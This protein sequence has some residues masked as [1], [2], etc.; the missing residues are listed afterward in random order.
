[1]FIYSCYGLCFCAP[2]PQKS[3]V[4]A[5]TLNIVV[6]GG[7][8]FGEIIRFRWV[9]LCDGICRLVGRGR[10]QSPPSPL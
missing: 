3:Y 9:R 6:L 5:L 10:D 8:A 1:M 2:C 7:G 4:E